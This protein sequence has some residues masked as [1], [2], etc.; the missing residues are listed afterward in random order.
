MTRTQQL[1][2]GRASGPDVTGGATGRQKTHS[3]GGS[4]GE[5]Q[6][7]LTRTTPHRTQLP[8]PPPGPARW[9]SGIC[10]GV[11]LI[12]VAAS[13]CGS[14]LS[15]DE[16]VA[17]QA[18]VPVSAGAQG[19]G[20]T[21]G[22]P[23]TAGAAGPAGAPLGEQG[24]SSIGGA[25]GAAPGEPASGAPGADPGGPGAA[26]AAGAAAAAQ[27]PG[28][29][30]GT[31][32]S[33]KRCSGKESTVKLGHIGT[34]SGPA[35]AS[36][37]GADVM[38]QV[39]ARDVNARGGVNCH[40]VQI[41]VANDDGNPARTRSIAKDMVENKRVIAFVSPLLPLSLAGLT[42]YLEERQI[43]SV[44]GDGLSRAWWNSKVLFPQTTYFEDTAVAVARIS[45]Q[46]Y[47]KRKIGLIT[48]REVAGCPEAKAILSDPK[49]E[50]RAG[51]EVVSS[52]EVSLTQPDYTAECLSARDA[53]AQMLWLGLD[54]ESV[55]RVARSCGSQGYNPLI[56]YVSTGL[57]LSLAND[58]NIKELASAAP[59]FPFVANDFPAARDF[60]AAAKKYAPDL[61]LN[62]MAAQVW[63]GGKLFEAAAKELPA[64]PKP[65]HVMDGL[66]RVKGETLGG[67]VSPLT[68]T[69][70]QLPAKSGCYFSL[71][72]RKNSFAT[73]WGT[74]AECP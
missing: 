43:P 41:F 13:G 17:R 73:P 48:C 67:L 38:A 54:A 40:P 33:G 58:P 22:A 12:A 36:Y 57:Q 18:A 68:F 4:T 30:A 2:S 9:R 66:Y 74:K 44:G 62:G 39:W 31:S 50:K 25:A 56:G 29:A 11:L 47:D 70:G 5:G 16:I 53:G 28:S 65:S 21:I 8:A 7:M 52:A 49:N 35:G 27:A 45:V 26:G 59:V 6:S 55:S 23:G 1:A 3:V 20:V 37:K 15:Y 32:A 10:L 71:A 42:A 69:R 51:Y 60:Q 14:R 19:S 24:T 34:Y 46:R 63:A 72:I 64:D 61:R